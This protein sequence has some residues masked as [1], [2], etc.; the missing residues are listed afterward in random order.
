MTSKALVGPLPTVRFHGGPGNSMFDNPDP[1]KVVYEPPRDTCDPRYRARTGHR[2]AC[3]CREAEFAEDRQE[4]RAVWRELE[5]TVGEVLAGHPTWQ[6]SADGQLFTGCMCTGCQIAR[7]GHL[8]P[9]YRSNPSGAT[10]D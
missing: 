4:H 5:E 2:V 10:S 3:D 9:S 7:A 8:W 1:P 6:W